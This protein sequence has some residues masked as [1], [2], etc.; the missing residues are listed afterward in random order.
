M[1]HDS[2]TRKRA[3]RLHSED[4]FTLLVETFPALV[5]AFTPSQINLVQNVLDAAVVNPDVDHEY[6]EMLKKAVIGVVG[7]RLIYDARKERKADRILDQ[8]VAVSERDRHIRLDAK[9]L[10]D[11]G[12]FE[13]LTDNPDEAKVLSNIKATIKEKG[14]W[15]RIYQ[16]F[17]KSQT[18]PSRSILDPRNFQVWLS[19]GYD[20]ESIPTSSGRIGR[21]ELL[22]TGIF[23]KA[24]TDGVTN[25]KVNKTL[26]QQIDIL[27]VEIEDNIK[28]HR[29]LVDRYED[30]LPGV[31]EVS[32]WA[33]DADL[34]DISIWNNA[35]R[36]LSRASELRLLDKT[37]GAEAFLFAAAIETVNAAQ[38]VAD[39][40]NNSIRGAAKV[41]GVL[42]AVVVV[43]AVLETVF[44]AFNIVCAVRSLAEMSRIAG[45][46][47]K[48]ISRESPEWA[49][50]LASVR[51]FRMP[52]EQYHGRNRRLRNGDRGLKEQMRIGRILGRVLS[53]TMFCVT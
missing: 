41:V 29:R 27:E 48:K 7:G 18:D 4:A 22:A 46:L 53:K 45:E 37:P 38:D 17:V 10:I 6:S 25:G 34:P 40:R 31:A 20:G 16:P 8:K 5:E 36:F 42:K 51:Y 19:V 52:K 32:D 21:D 30:A 3:K 33:G 14:I 24:Y 28:E 43:T 35:K 49:S 39:Y 11:A 13:P 26:K 15:L 2:E 50:E 23:A 12:A 1:G 9:D 47:V 44:Q